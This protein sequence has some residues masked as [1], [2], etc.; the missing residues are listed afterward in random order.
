M[1][2]RKECME[3]VWEDVYNIYMYARGRLSAIWGGTYT[4]TTSSK[5]TRRLEW[6]L[7]TFNELSTL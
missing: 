4:P 7:F 6:A 1:Y 3:S 2:L 5:A